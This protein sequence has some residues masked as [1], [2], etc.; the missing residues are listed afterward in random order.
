MHSQSFI[1]SMTALSVLPIVENVHG[2]GRL[3]RGRTSG[4]RARKAEQAW[5]H[6]R[7]SS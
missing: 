3:P 1:S 2:R 5:N 7:H 6:E 4:R